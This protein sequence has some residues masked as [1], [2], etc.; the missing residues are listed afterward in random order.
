MLI[1][2]RIFGEARLL[3]DSDRSEFFRGVEKLDTSL[4]S[5][6]TDESKYDFLV[7]ALFSRAFFRRFGESI[8]SSSLDSDSL[9]R[10]F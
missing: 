2:P 8:T 3:A 1:S 7:N 4:G 9:S 5:K 10:P 6:S